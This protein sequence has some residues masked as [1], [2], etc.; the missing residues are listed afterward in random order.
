MPSRATFRTTRW[1]LVLA[2]G[3]PRDAEAGE[4]LS[5]LCHGYWPP[6][7]AYARRALPTIEDAQ[8]A[9]QAFFVHL[10]ERNLP[11][12][13]RRERGR[14]R[15][16]L[17]AAFQHFLANRRTLARAAKRG[18]GRVPLSLDFAA[19][20]RTAP[21]PI[22]ADLPPDRAYD[23]A[24]ALALLERVLARLRAE[25]DSAGRS[26]QFDALKGFLT[27]GDDGSVAAAAEA[28]EQPEA[29]VRVAV[30]RLRKRYRALL[31]AEIS[32]TVAGPEEV[33]DE[34][35]WLFAALGP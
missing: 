10:L 12:A 1:S 16:F 26:A 27:A 19:A 6:L 34:I 28:L 11:A 7:Y 5:E 8:D 30:H 4:A 2:A 23:R 13:A 33:D 35:R 18:G 21:Q 9:T 17:L 25:H 31:R 24:W 20:E 14:F 32:E 3:R 29:T 22:A 15:S